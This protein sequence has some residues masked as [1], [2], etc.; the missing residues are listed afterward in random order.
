MKYYFKYRSAITGKFVSE[1]YALKHQRTTV[2]ER[3]K[4]YP[5][6]IKPNSKSNGSTVVRKKK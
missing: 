6:S 3:V 4:K 2:R 5:N 1:K